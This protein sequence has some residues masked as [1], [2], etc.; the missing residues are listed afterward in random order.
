MKITEYSTEVD[1]ACNYCDRGELSLSETSLV[2]PYDTVYE[3]K[4][5]DVRSR[6]CKEC[7]KELQELLQ[8]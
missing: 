6:F 3:L 8:K 2:Y 4:G 1:G 5:Y 7:L